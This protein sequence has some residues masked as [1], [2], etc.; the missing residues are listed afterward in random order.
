MIRFLVGLVLALAALVGAYV[1]EGGT[2]L[3]LLGLSAFLITF[4]MPFFGVL[5]V[6]K[7]GDWTKAWRDAFQREADASSVKVSLD[8][9]R[10]GEFASYLSGLVAFLVGLVLILGN[11]NVPQEQIAHAFGAG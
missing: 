4:F 9:W 5:A 3:T 1:I 11:L 7:F 8:I 10:F 6:W 2:P